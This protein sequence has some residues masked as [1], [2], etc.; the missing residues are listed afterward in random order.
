MVQEPTGLTQRTPCA[1]Q[2]P[3]PL[4]DSLLQRGGGHDI[5]KMLGRKV[6][7]STVHSPVSLIPGQCLPNG[8]SNQGGLLP[9]A[10]TSGDHALVT[11]YLSVIAYSQL[12]M[13][14]A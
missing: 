10:C 7:W 9:E 12:K 4:A 2:T 14:K 5:W 11:A 6:P 8:V 1:T 13:Q 3:A